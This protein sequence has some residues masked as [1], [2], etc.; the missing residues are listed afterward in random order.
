[1]QKVAQDRREPVFDRAP[2]R[3]LARQ[4]G[5][6][7]PVRAAEVVIRQRRNPVVQRVIA[8]SD[9]RDERADAVRNLH[10]DLAGYSEGGIVHESSSCSFIDSSSDSLS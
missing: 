10:R 6:E 3:S 5:D 9:R 8:K 2:V 4:R 7:E 1:M